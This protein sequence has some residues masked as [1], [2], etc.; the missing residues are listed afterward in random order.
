MVRDIDPL[1]IMHR[2]HDKMW[3][4]RK[5]ILEE[6]EDFFMH[7][8]FDQYIKNDD[9]RTFMFSLIDLLKQKIPKLN[10][11]EKKELWKLIQNMLESVIKYKMIVSK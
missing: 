9:N 4:Y 1:F 3:I 7:N 2:C 6:N 5:E 11:S 8:K 10:M